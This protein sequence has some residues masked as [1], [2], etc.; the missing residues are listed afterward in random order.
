[1]ASNRTVI[2]VVAVCFLALAC[3]VLW[4][5]NQANQSRAALLQVQLASLQCTDTS[6][7]AI[8][9]T[10]QRAQVEIEVIAKKAHID[11]FS[12][13]SSRTI[14]RNGSMN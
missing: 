4:M 7:V 5:D 11:E 6:H 14:S 13:G 3:A 2:A 10:A 1:M 9:P 8:K 12:P